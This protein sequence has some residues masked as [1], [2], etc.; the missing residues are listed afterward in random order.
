MKL[1]VGLGNPGSKY[2][3]T[4]HNVG[5]LALNFFVASS[6]YQVASQKNKFDS[7]IH[8]SDNSDTDS[9]YSDYIFI[10][11]QTFM[12]KSGE[13]VKKICNF[14]KTDVSKD[15]LV[16]HDDIDLPLGEIRYTESSSS[17][18]HNGVQNI[19][20]SLGTQNFSRIRI[21]IE[22]RKEED[23]MPTENFVLANFSQTELETLTTVVFPKT[24]TY[25]TKFLQF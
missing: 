23:R 24:E 16:I 10:K 15:L 4:R 13:A 8:P 19:I 9:G 5:F 6:K 1:I 18:G 12:N 3:Q 21:G 7:I 20:D 11:P 2:E 17:A 25:L 14:Y 22:N